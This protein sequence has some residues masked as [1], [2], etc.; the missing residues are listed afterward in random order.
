[1]IQYSNTYLTLPAHFYQRGQAQ[2]FANP[3]LIA[4]NHE[5]ADTI[6]NLET[7]NW[8]DEQLAQYFS[9]QI[10]HEGLTP[11][12]L[13]YAGHQFGHFN[14]T[15]GDGRALLLGEILTPSGARY[16]LQ[17]KGSGPTVY[18]RGGD[19]FSAIGPVIREYLVSEAMFHL[20]VPTT[21]ALC[22]VATN[23]SV[24]R[25]NE[26]PGGVLTR[27]AASHIRIGTFE[28]FAARHDH[29]AVKKLADYTIERHYPQAKESQSPYLTLI[30]LCANN[31]AK[32]IAKW[33]GFGFI[34]GV[35]NTDNMAVSGE[36][37][38][39]GPCAFMDEFKHDQVFSF[40]DR[41]GRYAYGNQIHIGK[42]N[43][44]RFASALLPLLGSI[45]EAQAKLEELFP[46]YDRAWQTQLNL[47]LGM[48]TEAKLAEEFLQLL[49]THQLDFTNS[50]YALGQNETALDQ[51]PDIMEWRQ[52][53][54]AIIPY[55]QAQSVMR[56]NNPYIIPRNHQIEKAIQLAQIGDYS[57]FIRLHAAFKH[58]YE[59]LV[60]NHELTQPPRADER[61]KNT[62]CGT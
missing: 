41:H 3:Q 6:L 17:L 8:S 28:Y 61:I 5:L 25:E 50:F 46:L 52:N 49:E 55:E 13:N 58:P 32:L 18:S 24:Y 62:F 39:Y 44:S 31:W 37:I 38:D 57:H 19:G 15:L 26:L 9:G 47:K 21:R 60:A 48:N 2:A 51:Y 22:A 12:S 16:D 23:Q 40:I 14:P 11:I 56:K 4:F 36:T 27:V 10:K 59:S 7:H 29:D 30:E 43:L 54:H 33:M 1:M 34:H 35:M 42:W 20:G 53:W 45:E